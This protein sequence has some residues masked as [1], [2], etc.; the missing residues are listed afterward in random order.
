VTAV[1]QPTADPKD[2]KK[3]TEKVKETNTNSSANMSGKR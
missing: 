1:P 3:L 2:A